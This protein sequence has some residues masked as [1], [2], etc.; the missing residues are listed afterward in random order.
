M[1]HST[2]GLPVVFVAP[3]VNGCMAEA[4]KVSVDE[5]Q[6]LPH[7]LARGHVEAHYGRSSLSVTHIV[8][9]VLGDLHELGVPK[10]YVWLEE[11]LEKQVQRVERSY[12][13]SPLIFRR[14]S[15][16]HQREFSNAIKI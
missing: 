4:K 1:H 2:G 16:S 3:I 15:T 10:T 14:F 11:S 6:C 8:S 13:N 12:S 9:W 5:F 7:E